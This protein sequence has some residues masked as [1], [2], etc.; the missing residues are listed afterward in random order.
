MN[1]NEND[2]EK[3]E[4]KLWTIWR[5]RTYKWNKWDKWFVVDSLSIR[6]DF[7]MQPFVHKKPQKHTRDVRCKMQTQCT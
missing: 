3:E 2:N 7:E 4:K 6:V 5:T 1:F